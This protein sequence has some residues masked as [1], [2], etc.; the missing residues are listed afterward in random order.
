[1]A[2]TTRKLYYS[3]NLNP[4][5]AVAVARHLN[6]PV[7]YVRFDPMGRDKEWVRAL[8]PNSRAPMLVEDGVPLWETDA[9]ALR[10]SQIS[11]TDFWPEHRMVEV[12]KWISWSAHHFTRAGDVL[13]F[14]RIVGPQFLPRPP[15]EVAIANAT[16]SFL[17]FAAIL[18]GALAGRTW[19][20]D[21]KLSY[22]DF[23]VASALP[24]AERAQLP[25]ADFPN[26]RAWNDRLNAID[27]WREPFA[28]L[29][30]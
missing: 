30:A 9:I 8:N 28:G 18:D 7:E 6:S 24:F 27:A 1:M 14:E 17:E 16:G 12:I 22:A 20:I 4:R 2:D 15:D 10:L 13:Y 3:P 29:A 11:G 5:V 21:D 25:L 23:R 19:L 26:V